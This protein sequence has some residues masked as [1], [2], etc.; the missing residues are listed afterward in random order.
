MLSED[1][2]E[3][4]KIIGENAV[5]KYSLSEISKKI[6]PN[7]QNYYLFI[8]TVKEGSEQWIIIYCI[9][10][11]TGA[12]LVMNLIREVIL[13]IFFGKKISK[14]ILKPFN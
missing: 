9:L 7:E 14:D 6:V 4:K 2:P 13:Y 3:I 5:S 1:N 12:Y 8:H 10:G 11:I